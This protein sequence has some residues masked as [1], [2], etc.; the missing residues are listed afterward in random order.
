VTRRKQGASTLDVG[1]G[2]NGRTLSMLAAQLRQRSLRGLQ[3]LDAEVPA[4]TVD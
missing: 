3:D 1:L 2:G 4:S